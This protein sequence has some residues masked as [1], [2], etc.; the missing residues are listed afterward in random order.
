[1]YWIFSVFSKL[2]GS[3]PNHLRENNYERLLTMKLIPPLYPLQN[4]LPNK[5]NLVPL[6]FASPFSTVWPN[7]CR[8]LAIRCSMIEL[9]RRQTLLPFLLNRRNCA[10]NIRYKW[11]GMLE[12]YHKKT[13]LRINSPG[14]EVKLLWNI[15][16]VII[17]G[18]KW[19][20]TCNVNIT[21]KEK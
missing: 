1:M 6:K 19:N 21:K 8:H 13:F 20:M 9:L 11:G 17:S 3:T 2:H 12:N 7:W 4:Y 18:Q 14:L 10:S 5:C 16:F 15:G